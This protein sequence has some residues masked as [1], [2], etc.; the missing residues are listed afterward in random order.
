MDSKERAALETLGKY[1]QI[2]QQ[3]ISKYEQ[4]VDD[5]NFVK[6][7]SNLIREQIAA[8]KHA[9]DERGNEMINQLQMQYKRVK[10]E[11]NFEYQKWKDIGI[12][13]NKTKQQCDNALKISEFHQL[14]TR[15]NT[16]LNVCDFI[17]S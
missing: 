15:R 16:I 4:Y 10:D 12:K 5:S 2:T 13:V 17:V 11:C 9:L 3:K 6:Q 8:M 1:A 14:E 7:Q